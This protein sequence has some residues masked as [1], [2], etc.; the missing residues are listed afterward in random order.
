MGTRSSPALLDFKPTRDLEASWL[1]CSKAESINLT[2]SFL[3]VGQE[4]VG[5]EAGPSEGAGCLSAGFPARYSYR[6]S[7]ASDVLHHGVHR[8]SSGLAFPCCISV[9]PKYL[10]LFSTQFIL[11]G[12]DCCQRVKDIC[13]VDLPNLDT[14]KAFWDCRAGHMPARI[15]VSLLPRDSCLSQKVYLWEGKKWPINRKCNKRK[16]QTKSDRLFSY[17]FVLWKTSICPLK[18]DQNTEMFP[19]ELANTDAK[20]VRAEIWRGY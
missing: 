17:H 9:K 8:I 20:G 14:G 16:R 3:Q 2:Q 19:N 11:N 13:N 7:L 15:S 12:K 6:T 18:L 1:T 4:D 5:N 10:C